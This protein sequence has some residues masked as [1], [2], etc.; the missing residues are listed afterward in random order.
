MARI[1]SREEM[2]I[3]SIGIRIAMRTG[4]RR[5]MTNTDTGRLED[6]MEAAKAH[7]RS[8]DERTFWVKNDLTVSSLS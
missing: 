8:Q 4:R 5:A 1:E 2:A 3:K 7:V 6:W